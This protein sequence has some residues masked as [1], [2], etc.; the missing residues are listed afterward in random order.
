MFH[1][2]MMGGMSLGFPDTCNTPGP[3][4]VM[5]IPYPNISVGPTCIPPTA[6]MTVLTMGTPSFNQATEVPMTNGDNA[7]VA[8]GVA[9]GMVMGPQEHTLGSLTILTGG[10]PSQ[11]MTSITGHNGMS[12]N[13]PGIT[14]VPSQIKVLVLG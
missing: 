11:R 9:S 5:P 10:S 13:C 1:S 14:L 3:T 7:G 2:T 6:S 8:M 4:G 12:E